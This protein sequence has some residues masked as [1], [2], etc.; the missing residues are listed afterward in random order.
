MEEEYKRIDFQY[1]IIMVRTK[2]FQSLM[3]RLGRNR[4]S[5]PLAWALLYLMP[6]AGGIGLFIFLTQVAIFFS[7]VVHQVGVV[8]RSVSPLAYLG[9]PGVN[10]YLPI[11]DGWA[12]LIVAMVIHE[13][14]HGVVARSL[15]FPVKTSGL[16]FFLFVPIGAF[17][18]VD[19]KALASARARDS[20]RILAA[21]AGVNFVLG[22]ICLLLLFSV[23]SSMSPGANG[24]AVTQVDTA[25]SVNNATVP[26]PA[27][28]AGIQPGDFI[29]AVN[30]IHYT[31]P[32][33][34]PGAPWYKPNQVINI[35]V[36][37]A[38]NEFTVK[39]V[40]LL[41]NPANSS[42]GFL[43]IHDESSSDLTAKV[44]TYTGS[45]FTR[46]ILYLCIPTFP[47]CQG[48]APFSD[49]QAIF[50]TSPYGSWTIPIANLLYWFFFLNFNLAI[51]NALP[52]YPL[53]GG[54]A[55]KAGLKGL[56]GPR[57]SEKTAVR[58]TALT[59]LAVVAMVVTL[60]LASYLN[61]I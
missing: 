37:R 45:F 1:G 3:D 56:A 57:L 32:G 55:F 11:V 52:I 6:V 14:A 26:T 13:G 53:D 30:G 41:A 46:P 43:G 31:D 50:Y 51:F 48:L 2:R 9:L 35:S 28:R 16:L 19:E 4:I 58:L 59:T 47:S 12:A 10:P 49:Q 42:L 29:L 25:I 15:G 24:L 54:Q 5:K 23:V 8:V 22:V 33:V 36:W 34:I 21:G 20:G 7:P 44:A 27:A 60:P 61:L 38:G 40:T 39:N 17:V 18:E